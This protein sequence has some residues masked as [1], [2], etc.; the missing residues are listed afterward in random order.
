MISSLL[1]TLSL[2]VTH[3]HTLFLFLSCLSPPLSHSLFHSPSPS[4]SL[5]YIYTR[6][7]TLINLS[8]PFISIGRIEINK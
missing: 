4:L 7:H 2:S 5:T 3:I 1:L 8:L 6:A